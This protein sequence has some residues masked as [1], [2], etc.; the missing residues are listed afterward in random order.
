V[1]SP[2]RRVVTG[3]DSSGRSVFLSDGSPPVVR[4]APNGALFYEL[5]STTSTPAPI[6]AGEPEPT[7]RPLVVPPD[8]DGTK[9]RINELPPGGVA[10]MHRT[11]SVDYGIV[12]EGEVVLM[13]D[14]GTETVLHA[15][16][17]VIQRGTNHRWENRSSATVRMVFVLVGGAFTPELQAV[18]G[19]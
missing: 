9:V 3:H 12:L 18:L 19:T 13:L 2:P 11:E 14:D 7:E 10:P 16:D 15:G 4:T 5:W 17:V 1:T 8:R 6:A